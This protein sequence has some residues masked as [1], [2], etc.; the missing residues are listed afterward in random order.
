M[1]QI[2][3]KVN[4]KRWAMV[5]GILL[6]TFSLLPSVLL[7]D[8]AYV[9]VHDQLD[10]EV[11]AYILNAKYPGEDSFPEFMSGTGNRE[12]L[13]PASYG[14]LLFY[15]IAKPAT[16]FMLNEVFVRIA[17]F[18][19]MF[20]LLRKWNVRSWIAYTAA[21]LF[22]L[23]DFYSVYGLSVMGQPLLLYAYFEAKDRKQG[24][25][26]YCI[27]FLFAC[28]SSPVLVGY[29]DI[30]VICGMMLVLVV[31]KKTGIRETGLFLLV[32]LLTYCILYRQLILQVLGGASYISH[33]SEWKNSPEGTW[34]SVFWYMF[35][36]GRYHAEANQSALVMW[37]VVATGTGVFLFRLWGTDE[38]QAYRRL[39]GL[40]AGILIVS[41]IY[42]TW[43]TEPVISWRQRLGGLFVSFNFQRFFWLNP[44]LWWA[45]FGLTAQLMIDTTRLLWM[46]D[47]GWKTTIRSLT[48]AVA[49][50]FIISAGFSVFKASPLKKNVIRLIRGARETDISFSSF[51]S[52]GMFREIGEYIGE[53]KESY[54]VGSVGLYPSIPL[55]NG[56]YCIDGYSNNYDVE[57]KH[58][59]RAIIGEELNKNEIIRT[60]YDNW[61]NRCYLFSAELGKKYHFTKAKPQEIREFRINTDA[62]CR[63]NCRFIFSGVRIQNAEET[64]LQFLRTFEDK[65]SLYQIWLYHV[66]ENE[67]TG[68]E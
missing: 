25:V 42:A 13:T 12:S 54:K 16:A 26:P 34:L 57:Y 47:G 33:R 58:I 48:L 4:I 24:I 27:A 66:A 14:T 38:K 10:G 7:G 45:A 40:F 51:F 1:N 37:I 68:E 21:F 56:F 63:Q 31:R 18:W 36:N 29:V 55:Y 23:L 39:L 49:L 35:R 64:G 15:M 8:K 32:L 53:P 3:E 50:I 52:E 62:L 44:L 22:S 6:F 30:I 2:R 11:P 17:A 41:A 46:K 67:R 59:F 28:F 5:L 19:G 43:Q 60:Y 65:D 9:I 61:G 20:L